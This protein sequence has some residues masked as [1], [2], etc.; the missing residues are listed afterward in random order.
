MKEAPRQL[1]F[2]EG[3]GVGGGGRDRRKKVPSVGEAGIFSGSTQCL[4]PSQT[5]SII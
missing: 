3:L 5:N 2:P 1:G 4:N